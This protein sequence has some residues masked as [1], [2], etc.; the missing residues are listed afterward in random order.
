[1]KIIPQADWGP[2]IMPRRWQSECQPILEQHFSAERPENGV[3]RA[4]MGSGK[5]LAIA[6]LC[7]SCEL[8]KNETIVVSTSS[9]YLVED[10]LDTIRARFG[11]DDFFQLKTIG[12]YY[13]HGKDVDTPIIVTCMPSVPELAEKLAV[14][15]KKVALWIADECCAEG[16]KIST[17]HGA[18]NIESLRVNDEIFGLDHKSG[19]VKTCR[20]QSVFKNKYH[21]SF[22]AVGDK[23][24]VTPDHPVFSNKAYLSAKYL[25]C[26]SSVYTIERKGG[27]H[28]IT[29]TAV[30]VVQDGVRV[31]IPSQMERPEEAVLLKELCIKKHEFTCMARREEGGTSCAHEGYE[32]R[33]WCAGKAPCALTLEEQSVS[34]SNSQGIG[35][36]KI[37]GENRLQ[38]A[39]WGQWHRLDRSAEITV[40]AFGLAHGSSGEDRNEGWFWL[41]DIVQDRYSERSADDR[42]RSGWGVAFIQSNKSQGR[43]EGCVFRI[44][45]MD[46]SK[47]LEPRGHQGP[48]WRGGAHHDGFV[49]N[50]ETETGNYFAEGILVHNC[51]RTEVKTI[52]DAYEVLTPERVCGWTATPFRADKAEGLSLF[53]KLLYDYGPAAA[54]KDGGVIVPWEIKSYDGPEVSIDEAMY[55]M[56]KDAQGAGIINSLD[57]ADADAYAQF[58]NDRNF[59][60]AAVHYKVPMKD[61]RS[62]LNDLEEG[63]LRAVIHCNMLQEGANFP[64]MRWMGL[65]RPVSSRVRFGQEVGRG[66]RADPNNP[67]KKSCIY[68]DPWNL[69]SLFSLDYKAVLGGEFDKAIT[70]ADEAKE[71][72]RLLVQEVFEMMRAIVEARAAKMAVPVAPLS[73][74]LTSLVHAFDVCRLIDRKISA[75]QWRG[76]RASERQLKALKNLKWATQKKVVPSIHQRALG[77]LSEYGELMSKGMASDLISIQMALAEPKSKWID[78]KNIDTAASEGLEKHE[79]RKVII[80]SMR[81]GTRPALPKLEQG[82]LFDTKRA[83]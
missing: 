9:I 22:V 32:G 2:G 33:A 79:K 6:Q 27:C 19:T 14:Y 61:I 39:Q 67:D 77:V 17:P 5:A 82:M 44:E 58:L 8:E 73:G 36:S 63:R 20:V 48:G 41:S 29:Q 45:G 25:D 13:T 7:K 34:R 80:P 15:G 66:L 30:R 69:F 75:R 16:T 38:C 28:G 21:G 3:V 83:K 74:Y 72:E 57:V 76:E 64:F 56:C 81:P 62:Y 43:K 55:S 35:P 68:Y 47:I 52:K 11:T 46:D 78:F 40:G 71:R 1:M 65:R 18:V 60:A 4:I 70:P 49:Y 54:L 59:P 53:S 12:S 26:L 42:N 50:I 51:H 31:P 23:L 37:E 24:L 10:L